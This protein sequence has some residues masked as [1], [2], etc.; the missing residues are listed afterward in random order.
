MLTAYAAVT[1]SN[2]LGAAD[3]LQ[4]RVR[5]EENRSDTYRSVEDTC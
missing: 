3:I 5:Q 4:E 2:G 1:I